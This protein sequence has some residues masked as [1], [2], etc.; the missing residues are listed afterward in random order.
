VE[1]RK[2]ILLSYGVLTALV[3][4]LAFGAIGLLGRMGPA[5]DEILFANIPSIEAGEEM[6]AMLAEE[7]DLIEFD[8]ALGAAKASSNL[9]GEALLIQGI[10]RGLEALKSGDHSARPLLMRDVRQLLHINREAMNRSGKAA[11]R[12]GTAGAWAS[13]LIALTAFVLTLVTLSRLQERVLT[14]LSELYAVSRAAR[15]GDMLRRCQVAAPPA[16]IKEI[17]TTFN[18]L[19]D[20]RQAAHDRVTETHRSSEHGVL[21]HL[22][23]RERDALYVVDPSGTI[24]AANNRGL[25]LLAEDP[26]GLDLRARLGRLP[27]GPPPADGAFDATP[28]SGAGWL[29]RVAVPEAMTE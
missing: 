1:L 26:G 4:L 14:P 6:L 15:A 13:V 28:V 8:R 9:A 25:R 7:G 3:L 19:L 12:L 17:I 2:D 11:Q 27:S 5:I 22:L 23:E 10:E 18:L 16:D 21:L 29:C 24:V 20:G